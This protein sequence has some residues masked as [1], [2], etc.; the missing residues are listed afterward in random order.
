MDEPGSG[1]PLILPADLIIEASRS[2]PLW[3]RARDWLLTTAVWLA[4]F[5]LI[6]DTFSYLRYLFQWLLQSEP[7]SA[8]LA[9]LAGIFATLQSYVLVIVMNAA[10]LVIWALYNRFR[11]RGRE[12]RK[13]S[14][15]VTLRDLARLYD[16]P[17]SD[18]AAWQLARI[19]ILHHDGAG[20]LTGVEV[21][22][23][24]RVDAAPAETI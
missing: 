10:V 1:I 11:F 9:R 4:Y 8:D 18:V 19:L 16:V 14:P 17:V 23:P 5:W 15:A 7:P 21:K 2:L 3:V 24:P 12:R 20:R 6:S 13:F 22:A